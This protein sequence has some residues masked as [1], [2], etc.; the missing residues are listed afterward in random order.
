MLST[1]FLA[2]LQCSQCQKHLDISKY[3]FQEFGTI[4]ESIL[5]DFLPFSSWNIPENQGRVFLEQKTTEGCA[6]TATRACVQSQIPDFQKLHNMR[7]KKSQSFGPTNW[8]D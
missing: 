1:I 7:R 4:L 3:I 2:T 5:V 8:V 6:A